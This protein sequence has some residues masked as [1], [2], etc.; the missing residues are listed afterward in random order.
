MFNQKAVAD[1]VIV[2]HWHHKNTYYVL[3][4]LEYFLDSETV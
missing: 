3:K 1:A 2:F 4:Y